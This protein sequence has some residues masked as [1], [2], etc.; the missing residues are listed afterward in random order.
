LEETSAAAVAAVVVLVVAVAA[1]AGAAAAAAA[2][3]AEMAVAGAS[4]PLEEVP[5]Q[6]T[7]ESS[8]RRDTPL[9]SSAST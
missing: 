2:R 4:R 8:S 5:E 6:R 9:K 1:A 7:G 3:G